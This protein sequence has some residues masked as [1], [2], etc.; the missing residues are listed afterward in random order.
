MMS[1]Y[2]AQM[3]TDD[4]IV[5]PPNS[6][7][8]GSEPRKRR[9]MAPALSLSLGRSE[10]VV[11]EEFL[12]AAISPSIDEEGDLALDLD[13]DAMETPSDSESLHFPSHDLDL[14]GKEGGGDGSE[15][16]LDKGQTPFATSFPH[17]HLIKHGQS[18]STP[19]PLLLHLFFF[20]PLLLL[21]SASSYF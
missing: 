14:E 13:L 19:P 1:W 21:L 3:N 10:S 7:A 2:E 20:P 17:G 12:S 9:L 11:S 16:S 15:V 6:L 4:V 8:L 18:S 5:A